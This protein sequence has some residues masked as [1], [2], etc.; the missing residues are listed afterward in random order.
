MLE[1]KKA[2]VNAGV[3]VAIA[4]GIIVCLTLYVG[5]S[6]SF[7]KTTKT[8]TMNNVTFTAPAIGSCIDLRGQE[9]I[10][11]PVVKNATVGDTVVPATNYTI[12]ESVST[13]DNLKR[14][15]YCTVGAEGIGDKNISYTYG[16][17][18]YIEDSGARSITSLIAIMAILAVIVFALYPTL[19]SG[20]D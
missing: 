17:E 15:R 18:G 8:L 10:D 9:L 20:F 12:T 7:G 6:D 2:E 19:K 3:L 14:I 1:S 16:P 11:T 5:M 4:V 13:V